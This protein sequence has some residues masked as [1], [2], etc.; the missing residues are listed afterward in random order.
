MLATVIRITTT[1]KVS[2][3]IMRTFIRIESR[4][5]ADM[6]KKKLSF[7]DRIMCKLLRKTIPKQNLGIYDQLMKVTVSIKW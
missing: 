6:L 1:S 7:K 2:I 5:N 3:D 4:K